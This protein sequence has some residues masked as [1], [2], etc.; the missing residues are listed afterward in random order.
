MKFFRLLRFSDECCFRWL[1]PKGAAER[2]GQPVG[3]PDARPRR[4]SLRT[5]KVSPKSD[6]ADPAT[7]A[8]FTN[9][10][11]SGNCASK[12]GLVVSSAYLQ[13]GEASAG[14]KGGGRYNQAVV[15]VL[16]NFAWIFGGVFFISFIRRYYPP[17]LSAKFPK[18]RMDTGL[19]PP[20]TRRFATLKF[21]QSARAT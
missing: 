19:Y 5:H 15:R 3:Y 16:R 11:G 17:S 7:P 8:Q 13:N 1:M 9:S 4:L 14:R 21:R 20:T 2:S 18:T 10:Y 6:L 12:W